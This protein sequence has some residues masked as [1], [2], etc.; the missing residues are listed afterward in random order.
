MPREK[1]RREILVEEAKA[2][3]L[4]YSKDYLKLDA[5][6]M[7]IPEER[8]AEAARVEQEKKWYKERQAKAKAKAKTKTKAKKAKSKNSSGGHSLNKRRKLK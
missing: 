6:M 1:T 5:Y 7:N 4:K 2:G 3:K 8:A